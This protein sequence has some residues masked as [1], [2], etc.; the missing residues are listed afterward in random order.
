M[1]SRTCAH[2][3][4]KR[5]ARVVC[6]TLC[7]VLLIAILEGALKPLQHLST[8]ISGK[9]S[10][11]S[12]G[13][14]PLL[15]SGRRSRNQNENHTR[16]SFK[17]GFY[18][19][20]LQGVA[21]AARQN[22]HRLDRFNA[23]FAKECPGLHVR[24]CRGVIDPRPGYG[25][26]Q[27]WT[28]CITRA[29]EEDD[30]DVAY[31]FEDDARFHDFIT[32]KGSA[33]IEDGHTFCDRSARERLWRSAPEDTFLLLLG[34]WHFR[35][36]GGRSFASGMPD[37]GT[38]Y[39]TDNSWGSYAWA[40]PSQENLRTLLD[41]F[42]SDLNGPPVKNIGG[43][44]SVIEMISPDETKHQHAIRAHLAAY[45]L[46]PLWFVHPA[47][48]SNTWGYTVK[49]DIPLETPPWSLDTLLF[50]FATCAILVIA[51]AFGVKSSEHRKHC[52]L[53][54]KET[55]RFFSRFSRACQRKN[56]IASTYAGRF[57]L[58]YLQQA[59]C[60]RVY[61][62]GVT[63]VLT[64]VTVV[65]FF[66]KDPSINNGWWTWLLLTAMLFVYFSFVSRAA[67]FFIFH[68]KKLSAHRRKSSCAAFAAF[69]LGMSCIFWSKVEVHFDYFAWRP[70]PRRSRLFGTP[71]DEK[72][73]YDE[74]QDCPDWS[75]NYADEQSFHMKAGGLKTVDL[76]M[77]L[78]HPKLAGLVFHLAV[79]RGDRS[80]G[81]N[82]SN[83]LNL[84]VIASP[85]DCEKHP[86]CWRRAM[87][88]FQQIDDILASLGM[89]ANAEEDI[90]MAGNGDFSSSTSLIDILY[91]PWD[92]PMMESI[93]YPV[94][95]YSR[96][97]RTKSGAGMGILIPYSYAF[98]E[99]ELSQL[100]LEENENPTKSLAIKSEKRAVFRG[101]MTGPLQKKWNEGTRG[102]FCVYLD[103]HP[104]I[105]EWVDFGIVG[106]NFW[107]HQFH[108][109][110]P[111]YGCGR[112]M[113]PRMSIASQN[114]KYNGLFLD[115]AGVQSYTDRMPNLL[116]LPGATVIHQDRNEGFA[117]F[118]IP[119]YAQPGVHMLRAAN[120]LSDVA[121]VVQAARD[122]V[123]ETQRISAAATL[124]VK[125]RLTDHACLCA[126]H[127]AM[128]SIRRMQLKGRTQ[129]QVGSM[130]IRSKGSS[131]SV[132]FPAN[133]S[134][135]VTSHGTAL[136]WERWNNG[137]TLIVMQTRDST[138][139]WLIFSS[140]ICF[141][142]AWQRIR[143]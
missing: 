127:S 41:G 1:R 11:A 61:L 10:R 53:S 65:V 96:S 31:F 39:E 19:A 35:Y 134:T 71:W 111:E 68:P 83:V 130:G 59:P 5:V 75:S 110:H 132:I 45:M 129:S 77:A 34:G 119:H 25:I 6:L 106:S 113:M 89:S 109:Q 137:G 85:K 42:K 72:P 95:Q 50:I 125:N 51:L 97:K 60:S 9:R 121:S 29:L 94:W 133:L 78:Q 55:V 140:L 13:S 63:A 40:V 135:Q 22:A 114:A 123:A 21:G 62:Y 2:A 116:A 101:S 84:H 24:P 102:K 27:T 66:W 58:T 26:A 56:R 7:A 69:C 32:D 105:A 37:I 4:L 103:K 8:S 20:T 138:L 98:S 70:L 93:R 81:A 23:Y 107:H 44:G 18:V 12:F 52:L 122:N 131:S 139:W 108:W 104:E 48:Y 142:F 64:L 128:E 80:A 87:F 115:M 88:L 92:D 15:E 67:A 112:G 36:G 16:R 30:V 28:H 117:D 91:W 54:L 14:I 73:F 46:S 126:V 49:E 76:E 120:N 43:N 86:F 143:G 82:G 79:V 118:L 47:G 17:E 74:N 124:L 33:M 57:M 141:I 136:I 99:Y 3:Q 38:F 90:W 100:M